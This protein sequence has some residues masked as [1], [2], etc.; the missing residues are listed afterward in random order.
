MDVSPRTVAAARR[1]RDTVLEAG[2]TMT[3]TSGDRSAT[4]GPDG[5]SGIVSS[6]P[7]HR[8]F[9]PPDGSF[10]D[11]DDFLPAPEITT[12]GDALI[13]RCRELA[14]LHD[15]D[16]TYLW[17]RKGG[18][19]KGKP[20]FGMCVKP[21]GLTAHFARCHF[22]IWIAADHLRESGFTN[23]QLE[24]LVYHE[25]LHTD[26][27][28]DDNEKSPTYGEA[29]FILRGHDNELF[30]DE[31]TRYGAWHHAHKAAADAW[32]QLAIGVGS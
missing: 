20:I 9:V 29:K 1:L 2:A 7:A 22:V 24:A 12:I 5:V 32:N 13:V 3:I 15:A 31:L 16:I 18:K 4:I 8:P 27:E 17:K 28:I 23:F 10:P 11:D 21:G 26:S 30:V 14:F 19:S 6:D 25:L